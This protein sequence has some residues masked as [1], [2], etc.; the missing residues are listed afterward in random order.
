MNRMLRK[1]V[2]VLAAITLAVGAL[3]A[4]ASL[5]PVTRADVFNSP[6][7]THV[8]LPFVARQAKVPPPYYVYLPAVTRSWQAGPA[9]DGALLVPDAVE[10]GQGEGLIDIDPEPEVR[11]AVPSGVGADR[12]CCQMR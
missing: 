1:E 9:G 7:M 10:E 4:A 11:V 5:I 2:V 8:Y 3:L 12:G 6:L